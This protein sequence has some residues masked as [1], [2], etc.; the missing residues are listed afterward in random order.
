MAPPSGNAPPAAPG[1]TRVTKLHDAVRTAQLRGLNAVRNGARTGAVVGCSIVVYEGVYIDPFRQIPMAG[2]GP[3]SFSLEFVGIKHVRLVFEK[4][5]G[6]IAN[7]PVS[8]TIKNIFVFD[9]RL[10]RRV[11]LMDIK[12]GA[13]AEFIRIKIDAPRLEDCTS[14]IMVFSGAKLTLVQSAIHEAR[15]AINSDDS[16]LHLEDSAISSTQ[17]DALVSLSNSSFEAKKTSFSNGD[18]LGISFRNS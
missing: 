5:D 4:L 2:E 11:S 6:F 10:D 15:R 16:T 13:N 7:G 12:E 8:L 3:T 14:A 9:R 18:E 1:E 17:P